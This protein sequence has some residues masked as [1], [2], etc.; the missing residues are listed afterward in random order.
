MKIRYGIH[1]HAVAECELQISRTR[2]FSEG[3]VDVGYTERWN[4]N[5]LLLAENNVALSIA[6]DTLN[7]A[8]AIQGQ[9]I[10]LLNDDGTRTAHRLRSKDCVGGTR[11]VEGPSFPEGSAMEYVSYRTF[12]VA[13]EGVVARKDVNLLAWTESISSEGGG[14]LDIHLQTLTGKPQK[15]RVAEHTPYKVV[16]EGIAV[17]QWRYPTP[18]QPIW[19]GDEV[20]PRRRINRKA[21]KRSGPMGSPQFTEFEISW[22]YEFESAGELQGDPT[23]QPE[24]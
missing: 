24:Q 6:I 9:D 16:Q 14:A 11:V 19:P 8:Y 17:G 22:R 3:G 15:Q 1:T 12:A 23:R 7:D 5:G 13:V 21:P 4:L 10:A 20:R 2:S 18:P